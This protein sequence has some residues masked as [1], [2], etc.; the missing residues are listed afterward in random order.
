MPTF[1]ERC[2]AFLTGFGSVLNLWPYTP[3]QDPP[4]GELL[5]RAARERAARLAGLAPVQPPWESDA[6]DHVRDRVGRLVGQMTLRAV[7][8]DPEIPAEVKA[9]VAD[10][11]YIEVGKGGVTPMPVGSSDGGTQFLVI[12]HPRRVLPGASS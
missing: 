2:A 11:Q 1:R 7:I 9:A 8:D 4:L 5:R 6:P 3:T 12:V 10:I